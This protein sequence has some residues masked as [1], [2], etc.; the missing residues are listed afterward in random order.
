MIHADELDAIVARAHALRISMP[1]L[2]R[3]AG[4]FPQSW[5]RAKKRGRAEYK[6]IKP[7]EIALSEME[8][9]KCSGIS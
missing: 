8:V 9:A 2:C 4:V 6:I 7:I 1:D 5:Y 3:K